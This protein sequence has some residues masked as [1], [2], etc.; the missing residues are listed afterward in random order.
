MQRTISVDARRLARLGAGILLAAVSGVRAGTTIT[1]AHPDA[2]GANIGWINACGDVTNGAAVGRHYCTGYVWSA[3][4]GWI[5]LGSGTPANGHAYANDSA[6]D[7]GV[8]HDGEGGLTGYAYG[9]NIGWVTFEQTHGQPRVDL[10]TGKLGGYA[11][12]ANVG[13]IG[14]SNGLGFVRTTTLD[15]GPDSDGDLLPDAYEYTHTNTLAALSGLGG[16]DADGDGATDLEE[17]RADTDP[18]DN[19]DRLEIVSLETDA[20][21]NRMAWT[22]RPT[23]LYRL[24]ATNSLAGGGAW[25][26]AGPGLI[27]PSAVSPMTQTVTDVTAAVQYYRVKAVVPLSE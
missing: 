7:W 8:N 22:S 5:K 27:G 23:R 19:M 4:C 25:P 18:L 20:A 6:T 1:P 15:P 14:L 11:W 13:W 12:G 9:A 3:N 16:H 24:E 10:H 26:D 21:T 2:Y 17:G